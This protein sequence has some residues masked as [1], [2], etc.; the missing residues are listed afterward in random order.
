MYVILCWV[1]WIY[2][3]LIYTVQN[4]Y[5][6][7]IVVA[8]SKQRYE[9]SNKLWNM[10]LTSFFLLLLLFFVS[11]IYFFAVCEIYIVCKSL[12]IYIFC[13]YSTLYGNRKR[14]EYPQCINSSSFSKLYILVL[15]FFCYILF[16]WSFHDVLNKNKIIT[17]KY[18]GSISGLYMC[19]IYIFWQNNL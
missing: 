12:N 8:T 15:F 16:L 18:M 10:F 19:W 6:S 17:L 7:V 1:R 14:L 5:V 13:I 9:R 2:Q 3:S 4:K 11:L